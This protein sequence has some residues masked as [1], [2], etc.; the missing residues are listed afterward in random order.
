[1]IEAAIELAE[2]GSSRRA[3]RNFCYSR[4][5]ATVVCRYGTFTLLMKGSKCNNKP[6]KMPYLQHLSNEIESIAGCRTGSLLAKSHNILQYNTDEEQIDHA[7]KG[8]YK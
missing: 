3:S 4:P 8:T 5:S 7:P 2:R 1:M 6:M